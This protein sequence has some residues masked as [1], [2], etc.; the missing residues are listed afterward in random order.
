MN[1]TRSQIFYTIASLIL[2]SAAAFAAP[3]EAPTVPTCWSKP[4][5]GV[6]KAENFT[7]ETRAGGALSLLFDGMKISLQG[8]TKALTATRSTSFSAL[9][10]S[11]KGEMVKTVRV[12]VRGHCT[13]E[14][15]G[16]VHLAITS[17][18]TT[19]IVRLSNSKTNKGDIRYEFTAPVTKVSGSGEK[20][21][22]RLAVSIAL[23]AERTTPGSNIFT[24]L[25]ALDIA[26][27]LK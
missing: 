25:D 19:K 26:S 10:T 1:H 5:A 9:L 20:T 14:P 18:E 23:T 4:E 8:G 6:G 15:G 11:Y 21:A 17:G 27:P 13:A 7:G 2:S 12:T 3:P 24:K 16:K 22:C